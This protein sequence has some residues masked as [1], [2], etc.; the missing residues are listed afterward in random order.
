[1]KKNTTPFLRVGERTLYMDLVLV[2]YRHPILFTCLDDSGVTYLATCFR[3]D[4]Q[5]KDW[6]IA[7]VTP[8]EVVSLLLNK[9][10]IRDAFPHGDAPVCWA[11]LNAEMDSPAVTCHPASDIPQKYFPTPGMYMDSDEAEFREELSILRSRIATWEASNAFRYTL[12]HQIF[13]FSILTYTLLSAG[14]RSIDLDCE[15]VF[16]KKAEVFL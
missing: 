16:T 7:E 5:E 14:R 11:K 6:L 2:E 9:I 4:A 1:M 8:E 12:S 10:T 3:A 15:N 13:N